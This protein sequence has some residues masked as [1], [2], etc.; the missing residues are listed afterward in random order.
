VTIS[1][2]FCRQFRDH[3]YEIFVVPVLKL[4]CWRDTLEQA[5]NIKLTSTKQPST[6]WY[7]YK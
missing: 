5:D 4:C 7:A 3:F 2:P 6:I 1:I